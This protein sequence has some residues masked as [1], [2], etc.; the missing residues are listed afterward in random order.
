MGDEALADPNDVCALNFLPAV[1]LSGPLSWRNLA[2]RRRIS[3]YF[4]LL[5]TYPGSFFSIPGF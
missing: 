4:I 3:S 1:C 5:T 2:E